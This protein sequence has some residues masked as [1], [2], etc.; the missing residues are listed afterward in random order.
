V[1]IYARRLVIGG[2]KQ[3]RKLFEIIRKQYPSATT[4]TGLRQMPLLWSATTMSRI[5]TVLREYPKHGQ[6]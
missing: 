5:E 3:A 2:K 4:V 6:E 1:G